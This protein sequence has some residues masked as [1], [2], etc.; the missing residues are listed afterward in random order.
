MKFPLPSWHSSHPQSPLHSNEIERR[1]TLLEAG[2]AYQDEINEDNEKRIERHS[3]Q[4]TLH[5]RA[6]LIMAGVLQLLMQERYPVIA[7]VIKEYLP[8]FGSGSPS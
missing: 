2:N 5:E 4:L 8:N 3:S 6:I 7:K 1:L